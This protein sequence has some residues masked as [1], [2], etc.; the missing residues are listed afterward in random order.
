MLTRRARIELTARLRTLAAQHGF[1]AGRV[2]IRDQRSRW[3][4]CSPRGDISLNWRLVTMPDTCATTCSCTS[5]RTCASRITRAL[6][7]AHV[8]NLSRLARCQ[9]VATGARSS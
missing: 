4:S 9:A 1:E 5:S 6:L 7:A 8:A 3:G 2:T